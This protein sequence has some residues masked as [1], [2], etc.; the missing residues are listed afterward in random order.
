MNVRAILMVGPPAE[1]ETAEQLAGVPLALLDVVGK[2]VLHRVIERFAG[3]VDELAVIVTAGTPEAAACALPAGVP[4]SRWTVVATPEEMWRAAEQVFSDFAQNG[5]EAVIAMRLGAYAEIDLEHM[6][7]FH[8]DQGARVTAAVRDGMEFGAFVISA[9]R[10]NDAAFLF[11]HQF[12]ECRVPCI[13]YEF[14][15]YYQPLATGCDLRALTRDALLQRNAIRPIGREI[16]PGV[17]AGPRARIDRGVRLLAPAYVGAHA[18]VRAGAVLTRC[19]TLEHHTEVDCG[20]VV[21]DATLLPFS[22]LG[23]GLD[24]CQGIVGFRCLFD[25]RRDTVVE[26]SDAR[27][28]GMASAHAPV[29]ALASAASLAGFLPKHILLGLFGRAGRRAS[30]ELPTAVHASAVGTSALPQA[31]QKP[32]DFPSNLAVARRYGNE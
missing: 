13:Q 23:A 1:V 12:T 19:S 7:Q 9:S 14:R 8:L 30:Q 5:A 22:F 26:F 20:S 10:R 25:L 29:R 28:V 3:A 2:S 6:M 32:S 21:E 15:G 17:W 4:S 27:L 16:K 18:R 11:R 31:P 24:V